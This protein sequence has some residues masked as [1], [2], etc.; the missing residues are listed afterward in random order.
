MYFQHSP[1]LWAQHPDLVAGAVVASGITPDAVVDE[2]VSRYAEIAL[3]R[4]ATRTEAEL[5]EIQAWRRTFGQ[6]GLKPTRYRCASESLLRRFRK[7]KTLPRV[8][9]LVDLCNAISL[10]YA[11]PIAVFDTSKIDAGLEV[12]HATGKELYLTFADEVERPDPGE[13]IFVDESGRAHARRWTNRQSGLSAVRHH[14]G[15]VLI[16][17]EALHAS[18]A[19]DVLDLTATVT[20]EIRAVWPTRAWTTMLSETA[21]RLEFAP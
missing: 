11:V 20:D 13:V 9:P 12:R 21:P 6:M 15:G 4:L 5:P 17:V 19:M 1:D 18:A 7:E 14:T 2:Q 16:V 8:H 3:G 10:A